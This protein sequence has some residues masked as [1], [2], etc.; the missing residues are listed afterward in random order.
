MAA[1]LYT[2]LYTPN[3]NMADNS[4]IA[5]DKSHESEASQSLMFCFENV[6]AV[7][8]LLRHRFGMTFYVPECH[9]KGVKSS[10]AMKVFFS[11]SHSPLLGK[12]TMERSSRSPKELFLSLFVSF[13]S[14]RS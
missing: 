2:N 12:Q 9:Q 10:T 4:V 13:Q 8:V 5:R 7:K 14:G 6:S 3:A 1:P 11:A